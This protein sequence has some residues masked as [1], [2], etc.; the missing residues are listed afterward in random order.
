M[1]WRNTSSRND[2]LNAPCADLRAQQELHRPPLARMLRFFIPCLVMLDIF[3]GLLHR[4]P[5]LNF[6]HISSFGIRSVI[7][8]V[9]FILMFIVFHECPPGAVVPARLAYRLG[10][11]LNGTVIGGRA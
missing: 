7:R 2:E 6:D 4:T 9:R 1:G 3:S 8:F 11:F 5:D 10:D